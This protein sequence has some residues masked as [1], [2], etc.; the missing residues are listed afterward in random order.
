M[1]LRS[2]IQGLAGAI[3]PS[4]TDITALNPAGSLADTAQTA[5][6]DG[7]GNPVRMTLAT[8]LAWI[9]GHW[10]DLPAKSPPVVLTGPTVLDAS[11]HNRRFLVATTALTIS[12]PIG[13]ASVGI[14]FTCDIV[15]GSTGNV[16]FASGIAS[17]YPTLAAGQSARILAYNDGPNGV[18][19]ANV[20]R[21][22]IGG[23]VSTAPA[24]TLSGPAAVQFVAS[25]ATTASVPISVA[26]AN[27]SSAPTLQ[28]SLDSAAYAALPS[29]A[30]VTASAVGGLVLTLAGGS[31]TVTLKDSGSGLVSN[32]LTV[33]VESD[34][35]ASVPTAGW[36]VNQA[37][38]L[39]GATSTMAGLPTAYAVLWNGSAE[40]GSRQAFTSSATLAALSFT[41]AAANATT[42]IRVFDAPTGGNLLA[43]SVAITVAAAASAA[44]IFA[45][46]GSVVS[47]AWQFNSTTS[48]YHRNNVSDG[49]PNGTTTLTH[50]AYSNGSGIFV[51]RADGTAPEAGGSPTITTLTY[52]WVNSS[53][54]PVIDTNSQ[55]GTTGN[56][57]GGSALDNGATP[58]VGVNAAKYYWNYYSPNSPA[59]PG[60]WYQYY[61]LTDSAG[62]VT[63]AL[64]GPYTVV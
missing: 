27:Y 6:I 53:T 35:L 2:Y 18:G 9:Q 42:T 22:L 3:N 63:H 20:I 30:T 56:G 5:G 47:G 12:P 8:W 15:N 28:Y 1:P 51:N 33:V 64:C 31:H 61:T 10:P 46:N 14:G 24:I 32:A 48:A 34:V 19:G 44:P 37:H 55:Q 29:G 49:N 26:L 50:A 58:G 60:T 36:A 7:S 17:L 4:V 38:T 59:S 43:E 45:P 25:T 39:A 52:G 57:A 13:F 40:V 41:P 54:N 21:A 16:T 62:G 11:V 23:A